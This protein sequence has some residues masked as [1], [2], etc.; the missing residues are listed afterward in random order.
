MNDEISDIQQ[1]SVYIMKEQDLKP[2]VIT[3]FVLLKN[4][5]IYKI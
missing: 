4:Q 3:G 5:I 1:Y 2:L